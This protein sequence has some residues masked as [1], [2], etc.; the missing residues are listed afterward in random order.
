MHHCFWCGEMTL[1]I[2]SEPLW[3]LCPDCQTVLVEDMW[4]DIRLLEEGQAP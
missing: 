4:P 1:A 2:Y 3:Q